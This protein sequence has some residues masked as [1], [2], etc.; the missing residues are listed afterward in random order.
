MAV[1]LLLICSVYPVS[2]P[3]EKKGGVASNLYPATLSVGLLPLYSAETKEIVS[4]L[5][6]NDSS[7]KALLKTSYYLVGFVAAL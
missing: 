2:P 6:L 5:Q 7:V 1:C 3:P 4:K